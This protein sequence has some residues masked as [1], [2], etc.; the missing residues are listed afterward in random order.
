MLIDTILD[1][2]YNSK[3]P[4][5]VIEM[6]DEG[7]G[8]DKYDSLIKQLGKKAWQCAIC[9]LVLT[10]RRKLGWKLMSCSHVKSWVNLLTWLLIGCSLLCS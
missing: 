4:L 1:I 7:G 10:T 9:A 3:F 8:E 6:E 2:D 5:Q